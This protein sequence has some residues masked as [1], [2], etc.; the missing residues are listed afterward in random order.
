MNNICKYNIKTLVNLKDNQRLLIENDNKLVI[1]S[2]YFVNWRKI[3]NLKIIMQVYEHSFYHYLI[4]TKLPDKKLLSTNINLMELNIQEFNSG[5]I[6]LLEKS[7]DGILRMKKYY[8]YYDKKEGIYIYNIYKKL[9]NELNIIKEK[10]NLQKM[11]YTINNNLENNNLEN[12]NLENN[13]LENNNLENN[14]L[15]I[16]QLD[17]NTSNGLYIL[18]NKKYGIK[19]FSEFSNIPLSFSRV[20]FMF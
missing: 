16:I 12:N 7:L 6:I 5:I 2:R 19:D 8:E 13:N 3:K 1:D 15:E 17:K 14:N 11:N 9:K 20:L 10:N 18:Y 4:L